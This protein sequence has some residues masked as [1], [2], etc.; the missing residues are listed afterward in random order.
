MKVI[1]EALWTT[2]AYSISSLIH[3]FKAFDLI[4]NSLKYQNTMS[5]AA[6]IEPKKT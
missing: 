2:D 5:N 4:A 1:F 6:C 3:L